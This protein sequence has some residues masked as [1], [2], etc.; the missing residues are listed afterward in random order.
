MIISPMNRSMIR[1]LL[2]HL[3]YVVVIVAIAYGTV[4]FLMWVGWDLT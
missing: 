4:Q 2:L 3:I 1:D